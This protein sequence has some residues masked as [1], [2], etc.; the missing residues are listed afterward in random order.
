M[1][2]KFI[3]F[4]DHPNPKIRSYSIG[5]LS[6]FI[7]IVSESLMKNVDSFLAALFKRASDTDGDVRRH[8][9]QSLVLM[10]ASKPEKLMPSIGDVAEYMLYSTQDSNENVALDWLKTE[11]KST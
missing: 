11:S 6:H 5:A 2:P 4:S 7:P 3:Q 1:I 9:C 10:L 8:V